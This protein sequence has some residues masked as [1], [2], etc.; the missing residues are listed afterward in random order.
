[1]QNLSKGLVPTFSK[2]TEVTAHTPA[3]S[4]SVSI[5]QWN[6]MSFEMHCGIDGCGMG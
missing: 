3:T 6:E 1:M 5:N 2:E 4:Q